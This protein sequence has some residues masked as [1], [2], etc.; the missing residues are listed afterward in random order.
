MA[1]WPDVCH[2][3]ARLPG[4]L[5]G[6]AHEG[7]PAWYAGRHPFARL[8]VDDEGRELV[9]VWTGEMDSE[10]A[11]AAHRETFVRID[12]FRF[13]VSLWARLDRL[14]RRE[15]AELLLDSYDVRGGRRRRGAV[16]LVDLL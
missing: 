2:V 4:A 7:S 12:T 10:P 13:R 11:L 16:G 9:Q 14:D 1:S 6:E 5:L 8:R 3:A 15:L